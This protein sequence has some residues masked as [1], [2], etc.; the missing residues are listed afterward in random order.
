MTLECE[1]RRPAQR[2][3][4]LKGLTELRSGR[5][6]VMRQSGVLLSLTIC[7][8]EAAD[9]DHYTC[10][11]GTMKSHAQLT[12]ISEAR[13]P[14][15]CCCVLNEPPKQLVARWGDQDTCLEPNALT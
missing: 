5:K 7:C 9:T 8:L 2:V 14:S 4:W 10:D 13:P 12:V 1:T 11:V 6:Y 15:L 3:A